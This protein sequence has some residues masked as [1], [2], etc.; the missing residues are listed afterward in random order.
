MKINLK[1][2]ISK[3]HENGG[4]TTNLKYWKCEIPEC[5]GFAVLASDIYV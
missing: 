1:N 5:Q 4:P 2:K 3:F